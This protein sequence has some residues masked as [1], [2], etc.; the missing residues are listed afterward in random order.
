MHRMSSN[1]ILWHSVINVGVRRRA[2]DRFEK[3]YRIF[4]IKTVNAANR[5]FSG[6]R[7][8]LIAADCY[9]LPS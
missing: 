3:V 7:G 9:R 5:T 8:K 4:G 1:A 6:I 2:S